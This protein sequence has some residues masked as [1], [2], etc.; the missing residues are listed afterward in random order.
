MAGLAVWL[1]ALLSMTGGGAYRGAVAVRGA[2]GGFP[3]LALGPCRGLLGLARGFRLGLGRDAIRAHPRSA[4][5]GRGLLAGGWA[6]RLLVAPSG[7][8]D[9]GALGEHA[10][11]RRGRLGCIRDRRRSGSGRRCGSRRRGR[12]LTLGRGHGGG[13]D[14]TDLLDAGERAGKAL[15]RSAAG[16]D[17]GR[18]RKQRDRRA[19]RKR[20]KRVCP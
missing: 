9:A 5:R 8:L 12:R 6:R 15:E 18:E 16:K 3:R 13:D 7:P 14:A 19:Q 17:E 11:S 1:I 2:A 4:E 20:P 10:C